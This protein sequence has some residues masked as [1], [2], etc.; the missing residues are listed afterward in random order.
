MIRN[1]DGFNEDLGKKNNSKLLEKTCVLVNG[2][3]E[4]IR[5]GCTMLKDSEQIF[6][7]SELLI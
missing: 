2:C 3:A 1:M 4:K 5:S 7:G 6:S